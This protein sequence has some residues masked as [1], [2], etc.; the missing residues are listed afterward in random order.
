MKARRVRFA[1]GFDRSLRKLSSTEDQERAISAIRQFI[2]RSA[3]NALQPEKKKGLKDIR[4]FRV[5]DSIRIFYVL[6]RNA[7]GAYSELFFV[8]RHD[9]YRTIKRKKPRMGRRLT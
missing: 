4:T 5:T 6:K 3:E 2:E 1:P 8:G 7:E 9:E